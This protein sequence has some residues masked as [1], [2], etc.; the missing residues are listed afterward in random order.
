M[1]DSQRSRLAGANHEAAKSKTEQADDFIQFTTDQSPLAQMKRR[2][3][4]ALRLPPL[5]TG[6]RDPQFGR[7]A[8]GRDVA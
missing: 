3:E 1:S 7:R 6:F 8:D 5:A 4:A 2:R